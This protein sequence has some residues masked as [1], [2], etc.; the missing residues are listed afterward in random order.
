[1]ELSAQEVGGIRHRLYAIG[2]P[3]SLSSVFTKELE[4]WVMCS[5]IEWT[6][7]RLKALKVDLFR[8]KS[9]LTPLSWIRKNSS[10]DVGGIIG[11]LFRYS[12]KGPKQFF[13][14][15][16][17]LQSYTYFTFDSL[18]EN[19][20]VKFLNAINAP[21]E[22]I[23]LEIISIVKRS[24]KNTIGHLTIDR[25]NPVRLVTYRG[26]DSKKAPV[27][28]QSQTIQQ[29]KD[30]F[31]DLELFKT[32]EGATFY[33][34]YEDLYNPVLLGLKRFR[35]ALN[36]WY[37]PVNDPCTPSVYGGEIHFLQ[38][39]GG[40]LRSVAS[41]YRI[42]QMA[43]NPLGR[44]IFNIVKDL[45]WDC[46]FN[47]S[48]AQPY[49]Q[50]HLQKGLTV[51]SVD[52]SSATDYFPLGLQ[53]AALQ[54]I[55]GNVLDISLFEDISRSQWKSPLGD[56]RWNKGQ[57]L[58]LYP[59]FGAFTLTH[60]LLLNALNNFS[61]N[62]EFFV[63]GDDV[64]ILK[65]ELYFKYINAL[66]TL[67]CPYSLDKSLSS[68]ELS[69]FA[70]KII[71]SN[72]VFPQY[73]WRKMSDDNF[74]DLC[75]NLGKRSRS[76][77]TPRQKFVFDHVCHLIEPLGLNMSYPNSN[78]ADMIYKTLQLLPE[79]KILGSLVD[80]IKVVH[81]RC[82]ELPPRPGL[83]SFN[84]G[85]IDFALATFDEK[86]VET[87]RTTIFG[88][89]VEFRKELAELFSDLPEALGLVPR[90]PPKFVS[91]SRLSTLERYERMIRDWH[92]QT[93]FHRG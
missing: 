83:L 57:P 69:E 85:E 87:F 84:K 12:D 80:L 25:S 56:L 61:H 27:P 30:P 34:K 5:G 52:L 1:M 22:E 21:E 20:K 53:L 14:T 79:G 17:C 26:S 38:E 37:V 93:L 58:G 90:L 45:P 62:N 4:K 42:H 31:L 46:T 47:Q 3:N 75:K 29:S 72:E 51:H 60:G 77:L 86:V 71:T 18:S 15:V 32:K 70:G 64:V 88:R 91:P 9:H 10:G 89:M 11:A 81:N 41:P 76:L 54:Q 82:Y 73:K 68:S 6:I 48:K 65:D 35:H 24:A 59:S 50:E 16:Q 67:G 66:K 7:G 74:L 28:F 55:F 92:D 63:V 43:L 40:K 2:L 44:A 78:L 36:L 39:P 8:R 13:R 33:K 19:Q 23:P 49:V